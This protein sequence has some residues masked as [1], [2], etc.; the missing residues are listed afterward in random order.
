MT[1]FAGTLP[2]GQVAS[3]FLVLLRC[4][5]FVVT[6]PILGHRAVPA[7]VKAGLAAVQ[8]DHAA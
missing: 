7:P 3:L 5:G 8:L 4:T 2:A 1:P 6:A